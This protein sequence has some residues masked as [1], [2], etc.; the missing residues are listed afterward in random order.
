M[1]VTA[2]Q[3]AQVL[4]ELTEGKQKADIE[5]SVKDFVACLAENRKLKIAEKIIDN[6]AKIYN[7]KKRIVEAEV[8][9]RKKLDEELMKKIKHFVRE[10]YGAKEVVLKN[11]INENIRGGIILKVRDEILDASIS[12]KLKTLEK[13]L[14]S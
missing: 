9:S 2:K 3:C 4:Y 10:K 14:I 1:R 6:F 12:G 13:I 8:I 5:K 7:Q 11:I